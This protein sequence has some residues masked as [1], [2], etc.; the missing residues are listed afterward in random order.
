MG[1]FPKTLPMQLTRSM[2]KTCKTIRQ[3]KHKGSDMDQFLRYTT[4]VLQ[5]IKKL[6]SN[7][8]S[9]TEI[10]NIASYQ[11]KL[12][13]AA[14]LPRFFRRKQVRME[15]GHNCPAGFGGN[16]TSPVEGAKGRLPVPLISQR[17]TWLPVSSLNCHK[18]PG[19]VFYSLMK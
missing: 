8:V 14:M 17:R 7:Q 13:S 3:K 4:N 2:A 16:P 9:P 11:S 1:R 19:V 6:L 15:P 10:Q 12:T 5:S 18:I